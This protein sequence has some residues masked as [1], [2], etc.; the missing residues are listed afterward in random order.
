M[1]YLLVGVFL[2]SG[3]ACIVSATIAMRS[4]PTSWSVDAALTEQV[5]L[6]AQRRAAEQFGVAVRVQ[7]VRVLEV[8]QNRV[9][10][11]VVVASQ[12]RQISVQSAVTRG[13]GGAIAIVS[14]LLTSIEPSSQAIFG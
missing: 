8:E 13:P 11:S 6:H 7:Q 10:Y 14:K 9:R 3:L 1:L 5:K 2:A 4:K 12:Y